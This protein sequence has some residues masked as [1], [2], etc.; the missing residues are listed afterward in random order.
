[1]NDNPRVANADRL[2]IWWKTH[3]EKTSELNRQRAFRRYHDRWHKEA[4]NPKAECNLC[5]PPQPQRVTA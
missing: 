5:Y 4:N 3:P 1:M 2:K